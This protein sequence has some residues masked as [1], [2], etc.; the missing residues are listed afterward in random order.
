MC[1]QEEYTKNGTKY[2]VL[3][4]IEIVNSTSLPKTVEKIPK[5]KLDIF[6]PDYE[7][8]RT[9]LEDLLAR[10]H[11][12]AAERTAELGKAIGI[13]HV[14]NTDKEPPVYTLPYH[15][16]RFQQYI[17]QQNIEEMLRLKKSERRL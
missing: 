2:I 6:D 11:G 15:S 7:K 3:G 8:H 9:E 5:A 10:N 14:I 17:L 1:V 4:K 13:K 16:A 12:I